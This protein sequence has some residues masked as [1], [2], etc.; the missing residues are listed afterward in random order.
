M[1]IFQVLKDQVIHLIKNR[2]MHV[3]HAYKKV[4]KETKKDSNM[5]TQWLIRFTTSFYH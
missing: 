5:I 3:R 2:R 4:P 1:S